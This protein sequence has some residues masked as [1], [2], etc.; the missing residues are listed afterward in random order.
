MRIE[1]ST[2]LVTGAAAS[3]VDSQKRCLS[4]EPVSTLFTT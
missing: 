2:A 1:G 4:G 3:A